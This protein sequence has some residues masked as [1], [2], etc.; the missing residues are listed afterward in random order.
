MRGHVSLKGKWR[1]QQQKQQTQKLKMNPNFFVSL[2]QGE[3]EKNI[4]LVLRSLG[5]RLILA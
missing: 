1:R 5:R 3:R 2:S 4:S